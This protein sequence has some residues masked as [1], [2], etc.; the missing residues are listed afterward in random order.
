M[1]D[2]WNLG[3]LRERDFALFFSGQAISLIGDGI[4]PIAL[5]FAVLDLGGSPTDLGI[6]LV[7]G[8]LPQTLF[9][10]VGGVWADRLPRRTIDARLRRRARRDPG[11]GRDAAAERPCAIWHLVVLVRAACDGSGVL[12]AG[13]HGARAAG[14]ARRDRLQQ[15]NA[16]LGITRSIAFGVGAALGGVF[17]SLVSSGGAVA[18]D[19]C[20][21]VISAACICGRQRARCSRRARRRASSPSCARASTEVRQSPLAAGWDS[22]TRSSS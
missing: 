19:A 1:S 6:V 2:G 7:A 5:A 10:L 14:R 15:A 12:H 21:F 4:F 11:R 13:G 8:I 18:L 17:V 20:T 22:P 9:V 3:V 16:L